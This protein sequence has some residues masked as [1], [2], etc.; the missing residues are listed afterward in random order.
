[1]R[2]DTFLKLGVV[3]TVIVALWLLHARPSR[4]L[5]VPRPIRPSRNARSRP[6]SRPRLL[7]RPNDLRGPAEASRFSIASTQR[8]PA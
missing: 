6:A 2:E 8:R 1:M 7:H 5:G 3:G 4:A